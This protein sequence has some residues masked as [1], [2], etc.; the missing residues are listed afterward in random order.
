MR[1]IRLT[2]PGV[3]KFEKMARAARDAKA[4]RALVMAKGTVK[5]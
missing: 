1:P 4:F 2:R 3:T 5:K